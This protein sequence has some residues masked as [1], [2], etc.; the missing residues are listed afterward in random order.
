VEI[1]VLIVVETAPLEPSLSLSKAQFWQPELALLY[2]V[3]IIHV[4]LEI[5]STRP[6]FSLIGDQPEK[7]DCQVDPWS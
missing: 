1:G 4:N 3:H 7:A 5:V 6:P 2:N